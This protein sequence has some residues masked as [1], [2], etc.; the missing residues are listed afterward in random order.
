MS[1]AA[2]FIFAII[3]YAILA[4][5]GCCDGSLQEDGQH[6][7]G[8]HVARVDSQKTALPYQ[9]PPE[10]RVTN[11][12]LDLAAI[13]RGKER[14]YSLL[15][16]ASSSTLTGHLARGR[17]LTIANPMPIRNANKTF[18]YGDGCWAVVD[19][20]LELLT[21]LTETNTALIRYFN[22]SG[23][24]PFDVAGSLCP[25]GT[26]FLGDPRELFHGYSLI[27]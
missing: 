25:S 14:I 26:L 23:R 24:R 2:G 12:D 3:T 21:L 8:R 20:T 15:E 22:P 18:Y 6:E 10:F 7:P 4:L 19:G 13:E 16:S 5:H 27:E 9:E 1:R 11:T 17:S